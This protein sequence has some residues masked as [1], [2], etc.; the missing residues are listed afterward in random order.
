[1][2]TDWQALDSFSFGDNPNL[3]D[4]LLA[5][6][7]DGSKTA[8][9]WDAGEGL[10]GVEVGKSMVVTDGE[11]RPR[12]VLETVELSQRRFDQIDLAFAHDE[13]EGDRTLESWRTGHQAYFTRTGVFSATVLLNC[14]RFRLV[15]ILNGEG[16]Q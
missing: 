9:C 3:A 2:S 16:G 1:M 6:V 12:A 7:L 8:T 5:L 4:A 15:Q 13:G 11:G 10:R 14:E